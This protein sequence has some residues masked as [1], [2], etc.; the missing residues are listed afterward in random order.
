MEL[1]F[2][3]YQVS[4]PT[5]VSKTFLAE[6]VSAKSATG[7]TAFQSRELD[8]G[9]DIQILPLPKDPTAFIAYETAML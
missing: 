4:K 6:R 7:Q 9:F 3:T 1:L 8:A 5:I 2:L